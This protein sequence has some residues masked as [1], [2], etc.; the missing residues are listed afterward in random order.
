MWTI[1]V[2][3]PYIV[4]GWFC[5]C[6]VVSISPA[7]HENG[8]HPRPR[9]HGV[10]TA[11]PYINSPFVLPSSEVSTKKS[12][13]DVLVEWHKG[14]KIER[15]KTSHCTI[16]SEKNQA[17]PLH[18]TDSKRESGGKT[19]SRVPFGRPPLDERE[20]RIGDISYF[21]FMNYRV[22]MHFARISE[23]ICLATDPLTV[24]F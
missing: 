8:L 20:H 9:A 22:Y 7:P 21:Q 13:C 2:Y 23:S 4:L 3:H 12:P 14:I 5:I 19:T 6:T 17:A 10:T 1:C 15:K 16:G 11:K 18:T 24:S